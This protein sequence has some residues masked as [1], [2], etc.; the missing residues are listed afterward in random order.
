MSFIGKTEDKYGHG[1]H[2]AGIIAGD[3]DHSDGP[4]RGIAPD[5]FVV[6]LR[7]LDDYGVGFISDVI[8]A[9]DW[10]RENKEQYYIRVGNLSLG[11]PWVSVRAHFA[12]ISKKMRPLGQRRVSSR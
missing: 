5:A 7:V 11:H 2:V 6:N 8:A 1:N 12:T 9:L 4:Y 3:G 10:V